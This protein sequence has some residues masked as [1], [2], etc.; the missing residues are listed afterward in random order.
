MGHNGLESGSAPWAATD[1]KKPVQVKS[2]AEIQAE[3]QKREQMIKQK[4]RE[5]AEREISMVAIEHAK[6]EKARSAVKMQSWSTI[7]AKN[8]PQPPLVV[9]NSVWSSNQTSMFILAIL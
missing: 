5:R 2:M 9:S 8:V 6:Q 3:E 1:L 4:E 7:I